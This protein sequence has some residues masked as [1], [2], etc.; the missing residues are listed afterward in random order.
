M[1]LVSLDCP[2][3]IAPSVVS[4]VYIALLNCS[5]DDLLFRC[6]PKITIHKFAL[7]KNCMPVIKKNSSIIPFRLVCQNVF[8]TG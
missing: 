1:L 8:G 2:F 7:V 5:F 4:N 6:V 3:L